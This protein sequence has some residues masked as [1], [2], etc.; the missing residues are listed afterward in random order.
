WA[1][2]AI[3]AE[4]LS[5]GGPQARYRG[6]NLYARLK[7]AGIDVASMGTLEPEQESDT[8]LQVIEERRNTYRKLILRDGRLLGAMLVGDTRAAAALA[9][10]LDR[11]DLLPEE[12]LEALCV[13]FAPAA[14]SGDR[15]ICNCHQVSEASIQTAVSAG[16]DSVAAVGVATRAG[17]GCGS[18]RSEIACIVSR[19]E[20][21]AVA[22]ANAE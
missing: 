2:A 8:V 22:N 20:R 16:A 4:V 21:K 5:G 7:V 10:A 12:P 9:Q 17:T 19:R 15:T 13:G 18:C 11:R 6:S 1:Q 3:L 14:A